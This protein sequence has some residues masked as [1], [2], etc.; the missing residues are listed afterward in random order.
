MASQRRVVMWEILFRVFQGRPQDSG[1]TGLSGAPAPHPSPGGHR[2]H[3]C[4]CVSVCPAPPS[5]P[6]S[7]CRDQTFKFTSELRAKAQK[8]E[9]QDSGPEAATRFRH[10]ARGQSVESDS[11]P[12]TQRPNATRADSLSRAG[13]GFPGRPCS[14]R[15][16]APRGRGPDCFSPQRRRARAVGGG[17]FFKTRRSRLRTSPWP[18]QVR[19]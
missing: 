4:C 15:P 10:P 9:G 5:V 16:P 13:R 2:R 11:G 1:G 17:F 19:G 8:Y 7:P 14:T 12:R 18:K 6:S 3:S